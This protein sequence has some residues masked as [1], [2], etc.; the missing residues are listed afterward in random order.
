MNI[1]DKYFCQ[2]KKVNYDQDFF[3]H[4]LIYTLVKIRPNYIYRNCQFIKIFIGNN[5]SKDIE[6][7][8]EVFSESY[9]FVEN[10]TYKN[11]FG[12]SENEFIKKCEKSLHDYSK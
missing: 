9:K 2:N 1:F 11:L 8:M 6:R 10:I 4:L 12:V 3:K 5:K 7:M